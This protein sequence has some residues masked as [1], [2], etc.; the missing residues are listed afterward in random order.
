MIDAGC[1]PSVQTYNMLISMFFEMGNLDE[2][3]DTWDEMDKRGCPRDT[4]TYCVMIEG[5]FSCN[6]VE[7]ACSLLEDVVNKGIKLPY[8]KFDS[9]LMQLS[10]IGDLRAIHRLS[11]HM[12]KFYNP[13]MERRFAL[14]EKRK[15]ISLRES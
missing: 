9:F 12:S 8:R 15:S 10:K 13:A 3:F 11:A 7:D 1:M 6:K 4:D 2:V 14:N 5:L